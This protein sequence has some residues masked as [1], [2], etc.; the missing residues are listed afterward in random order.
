MNERIHILAEQAGLYC[1]GTP[2]AWD[3]EAIE[4]FA[5]LIAKECVYWIKKDFE[6][7]EYC[8]KKS[9]YI[10]NTRHNV[11]EKDNV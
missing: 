10:N 5:Q 9:V 6:D 3:Q 2:D 8:Y 7:E 11:M 1:D 4:R